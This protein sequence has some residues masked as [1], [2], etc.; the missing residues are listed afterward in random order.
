MAR[1]FLTLLSAL[2][3]SALPAAAQVTPTDDA[4]FRR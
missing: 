2:A 1:H 3:I 4:Q